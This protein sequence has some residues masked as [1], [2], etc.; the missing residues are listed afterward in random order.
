MLP[1]EKVST[2]R[3]IFNG[4]VHFSV[5]AGVIL[6]RLVQPRELPASGRISD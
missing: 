4:S 3:T 2:D 5:H 6:G 1:L